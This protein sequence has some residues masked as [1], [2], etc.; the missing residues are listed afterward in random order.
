MPIA[1]LK[2]ISLYYE[3][4]GKGKPLVL[5]SGY[6]CDHTY[7]TSMLGQLADHH[8]ILIFDN[9]A[10]GQTADD[11]KP[12]TIDTMAKDTIGLI[13]HLGLK[14]PSLVGHS[15]GSMVALSVAHH[16]P[17]AINK[18]VL[19]DT[20]VA[21]S[22]RTTM[23]L[24]SLLNLRK[25]NI[26]LIDQVNVGLPWFYSNHFL[27]KPANITA[28][29]KML[30]KNPYPQSLADQERQLNAIIKFDAKA[31]LDK[32][33]HPALIISKTDDIITT[34][35]EGEHLADIMPGAKFVTLPGAHAIEKANELNKLILKFIV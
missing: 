18:I 20:G 15:M 6:T 22:P 26:P 9:R 33:H 25:E 27:S 12:F 29:T 19:V 13:E 17:H 23:I 24:K 32:I 30:S 3:L 28:Y 8:R 21:L 5:I 2:N 34:A 16:F 31:W 35:R 7:F 4:H 11:G 10:V 14:Q 1:H